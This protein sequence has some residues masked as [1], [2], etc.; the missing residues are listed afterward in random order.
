LLSASEQWRN[1]TA[2]ASDSWQTI[3]FPIKFPQNVFSVFASAANF[4]AGAT[5]TEKVTP[6]SAWVYDLSQCYIGTAGSAARSYYL[7]AVGV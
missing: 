4:Q 5:G 1:G 3:T 2:A 6:I 7:L